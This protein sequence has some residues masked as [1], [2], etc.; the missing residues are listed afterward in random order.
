MPPAP[1]YSFDFRREAV[2][3]LRTSGRPVPQ[4]AS[5]LGCSPQSLPNWARQVDVDEGRAEGLASGELEELRR[6]RRAARTLTEV[7]E[8]LRKAAAFFAKDSDTR[9]D[10]WVYRGEEGR[11]LDED[12]VRRAWRQPLPFT[13]G[14]VGCRRRASSMT[15]P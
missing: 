12:D 1:P 5:E 15:S 9:G 14:S 6:L 11:V 13:P 10:L 4:L 2:R 3:L 7:R 8:I